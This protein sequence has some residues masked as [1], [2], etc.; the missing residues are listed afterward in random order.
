MILHGII[1]FHFDP[2]KNE[3]FNT[4]VYRKQTLILCINSLN[5]GNL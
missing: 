1:W 4:G 5:K 2:Y 3:K